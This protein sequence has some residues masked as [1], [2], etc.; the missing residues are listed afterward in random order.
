MNNIEI[1]KKIDYNNKLIEELL[2]PNVFVLNNTVKKLLEENEEIRKKC[3]H[4]FSDGYC[5]YCDLS[6]EENK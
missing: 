4:I 3:S 2:S 6:E 1:R 5:I